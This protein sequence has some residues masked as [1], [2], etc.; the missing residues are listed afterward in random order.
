MPRPSQPQPFSELQQY[1][2]TYHSDPGYPAGRTG[3]VAW[4]LPRAVLGEILPLALRLVS[5][6][7]TAK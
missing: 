6:K 2:H 7:R 3:N 1:L 4:P 5:G